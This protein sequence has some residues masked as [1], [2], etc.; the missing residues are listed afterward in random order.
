[1]Y[2]TGRYVADSSSHGHD[3]VAYASRRSIIV[4]SMTLRFAALGDSITLGIGDPMPDGRWRGW[5]AL[6]AGA[7]DAPDG[8]ELHNL[9]VS[10]ARLIELPGAQLPAALHLRPHLV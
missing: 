7:L 5:S 10:G 3:G 8:V 9:A 4:E 2:G 1:M 6:L